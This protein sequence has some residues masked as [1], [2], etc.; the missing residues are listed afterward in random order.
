MIGLLLGTAW[1]CFAI[2]LF[3]LIQ[4]RLRG[5]DELELTKVTQKETAPHLSVIIPARNEQ[6]NIETCLGGLLQQTYPTQALEIIVVDDHST[7]E[8]AVIVRELMDAH[9]QIRLVEAG[10]LPEGWKGKSYAC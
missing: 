7:D 1:L 6:S 9:S 8:T 4:I 3:V 5:L 2:T 10:S